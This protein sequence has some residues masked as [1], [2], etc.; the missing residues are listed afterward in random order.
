MSLITWLIES[1]FLW[2][3]SWIFWFSLALAIES[4]RLCIT[5]CFCASTLLI[6][7]FF[8]CSAKIF[9]CSLIT[10]AIESCFACATRCILCCSLALTIESFRFNSSELFFASNSIFAI[11]S[12]LFCSINSLALLALFEISSSFFSF[13]FRSAIAISLCFSSWS[14]YKSII[15]S[16]TN[17]YWSFTKPTKSLYFIL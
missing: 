5:N 3:A 1:F 4:F 16:F 2:A 13:S 8:R 12:I 7:S 17:K 9:F 10:L 11:E 15:C 14:K 6:E